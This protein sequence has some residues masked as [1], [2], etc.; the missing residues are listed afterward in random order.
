MPC[1]YLLIE[2]SLGDE[3][4]LAQVLL[5]SCFI[6]LF[7]LHSRWGS[8]SLDEE[9]EVFLLIPQLLSRP[10]KILHPHDG[11]R[12]QKLKQG[13]LFLIGELSIYIWND[14]YHQQL[15]LAKLGFRVDYADGINI[16][17]KQFN[18]V[19]LLISE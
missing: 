5:D 13:N 12:R 9:V 17:S 10:L 3:L 8:N 11:I 14:A 6:L 4:I 15:P 16:I 7:I 1:G 19:R 18:S 2:C